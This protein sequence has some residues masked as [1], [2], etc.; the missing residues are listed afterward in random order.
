MKKIILSSAAVVFFTVS[1]FA[2]N[3]QS[4]LYRAIES[5]N[6]DSIAFAMKEGA[7]ANAAFEQVGY[8]QN[9][10]YK[11]YTPLMKAAAENKLNA[12]TALLSIKKIKI[13]ALTDQKSNY[14]FKLLSLKPSSV[15][16]KSIKGK[17][18]LMFAAQN[19][20]FD[21]VK[22]LVEAGASPL[23]SMEVNFLIKNGQT[24]NGVKVDG[25]NFTAKQLA[26][27]NGYSDIEEYLK[28]AKGNAL[29]SMWK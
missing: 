20:H 11:D 9:D 3:A 5:D 19:G 6:A 17:T 25:G 2:Q 26:G 23:L 14:Q 24:R 29:K 13:D 28:K 22:K 4:K 1:V 10:G 15:T 8:F 21:A 12:L 7:D 27:E 18:A 16:T